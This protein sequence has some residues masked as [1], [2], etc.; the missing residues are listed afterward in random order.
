MPSLPRWLLAA[1]ALLCP[2]PA[3]A[4]VPVLPPVNDVGTGLAL[5][6]KFVWFDLVTDRIDAARPFYEGLFG[7]TVEQVGPAPER[8]SVVSHAGRRIGGMLQREAARGT[9]GGARWVGL[10]SVPNVLQATQYATARGGK[11]IVAP[12]ELPR[13][14]AHAILRDPQGA[15]FGI[16]RSSS[17]DAPDVPLAPGMFVWADLLTR[18]P[19]AAA[20]F[21]RGLGGYAL[22]RTQVA[23]VEHLLLVAGPYARAGIS[24]LPPSVDR[25]GWLPFVQ[26]SDVLGTIGRA[27][28][29]GGKVLL[30]P[31]PELL[32][33]QVAVIADPSGAVIGVVNAPAPRKAAR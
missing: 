12:V 31:R 29:L 20:Q 21:Y 22:D 5:T 9:A 14:G 25:P 1:A 3:P 27:V 19:D 18:D 6:G 13:R 24:N 30:S 2:L 17:G 10:M 16:L 32:D 15:V 33:G 7:W 23:R 26:V 8:Y 28:I 4:A 11:V